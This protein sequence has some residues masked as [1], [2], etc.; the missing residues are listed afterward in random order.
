MYKLSDRSATLMTGYGLYMQNQFPAGTKVLS[1]KV[2]G[3]SLSLSPFI[4]GNRQVREV[5][6]PPQ[7]YQVHNRWIFISSALFVFRY[8]CVSNGAVLPLQILFISLRL[9]P[10]EHSP[11]KLLPF[12]RGW[13]FTSISAFQRECLP[14]HVMTNPAEGKALC[15]EQT[16]ALC[17]RIELWWTN[18]RA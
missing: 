7:L 1:C 2:C 12:V 3:L 10:F 6:L 13:F 15:A 16:S 11:R 4:G 5:K 9:H 14:L 8:C 17:S 18:P